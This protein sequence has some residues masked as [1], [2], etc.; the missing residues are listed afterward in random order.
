MTAELTELV[1]LRIFF[2]DALDRIEENERVLKSQKERIETL[3]YH[4][5]LCRDN[6]YQMCY[7]TVGVL[8]IG[9]E[10]DAAPGNPA[11]PAKK[12]RAKKAVQL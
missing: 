5:K 12:P 8:R 7:S 1:N 9:F 6:A 10:A 2:E 11:G 4:F 3:E